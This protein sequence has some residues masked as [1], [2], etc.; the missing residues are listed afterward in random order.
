MTVAFVS[1]AS[2]WSRGRGQIVCEPSP[3]R[4]TLIASAVQRSAHQRWRVALV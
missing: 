2:C 1:L 3:D 4:R